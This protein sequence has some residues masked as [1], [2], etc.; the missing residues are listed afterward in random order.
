MDEFALG[1]DVGGTH[2]RLG[3]ISRD[4]A[5]SEVL[6]VSR[7]EA[8]GGEEP[9]ALG[10]FLA[11][12]A[13]GRGKKISAAGVGI[14][15]TLD[16]SCRRILN[17]PNIPCLSGLNYAE[18][19]ADELGLP[20]FLENDTVMLLTGDIARLSLKA[21]G[22]LL[23]VYIGTGLGGALFYNGRPLK[24]KNGVNEIGHVPLLGKTEICTCG[25]IGCA[26]NYVSGRYLQ[27]LR[28]LKYPG[29]PIGE[30]F[31]AMAGSA[32]LRDFIEAAGALIAG[33]VNL[34]DPEAVV[35]GGGV[36]AMKGFPGKEIEAEIRR[37]AMKPQPS[38]G[39]ELI[40]PPA[41][42]YAGVLGA[43]LYALESLG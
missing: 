38:E 20:V 42:D 40:F 31:F 36:A 7:G 11:K 28:E 17:V 22:L 2:V 19:L 18:M 32:E 34:T 29:V 3:L 5:L 30:L 13:S 43:G 15:G 1:V 27:K 9:A 39:L 24:G 35:L 33:A 10:R 37:R 41:D 14:P 6:K 16:R 23:G 26:E 12:Y 8:F 25:N 4:G 21:E